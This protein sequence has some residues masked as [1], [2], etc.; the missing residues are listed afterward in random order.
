MKDETLT[1][2]YKPFALKSRKGVGGKTFDYVAT[3][4]VTDRLNQ[5]FKGNWSSEVVDFREIEDQVLIR[6][7]VVID[8][9]DIPGRFL[10]QEGYASQLIARYTSGPQKD[11][12][13]DVGN[14]Y[15]S[16]YS[17]AIK[18]A[19]EKWGVGLHLSRDAKDEE[20]MF[21]ETQSAG[22]NPS[23]GTNP[24]PSVVS[25]VQSFP[26]M[27]LPVSKSSTGS[28]NNLGGSDFFPPDFS[29]PPVDKKNPGPINTSRP[30][31]IVVSSGAVKD[32]PDFGLKPGA[33]K[34]IT[35]VTP[36]QQTAI[37][38]I[39]QWSNLTFK[40]LLDKSLKRST[41]LPESLDKIKY[42]DGIKIIQYGNTTR[43]LK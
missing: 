38:H 14:V 43:G 9:P 3:D 10:T 24:E 21:P 17:K 35:Y 28:P 31:N 42:E 7:R 1:E 6:V 5:V 19:V 20:S 13:I 39:M 2:L 40:E 23:V 11:K 18:V 22:I 33:N 41:D 36:I 30:E 37:E 12:I 4:D 15:K 34:E 32:V 29:L 26:A 8:H 25:E 16:A 27:D